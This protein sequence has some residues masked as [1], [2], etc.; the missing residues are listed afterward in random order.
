[1]LFFSEPSDQI[2]Y[3]AGSDRFIVKRAEQS[4][5]PRPFI[6]YSLFKKMMFDFHFCF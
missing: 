1:M 5:E 4:V 6:L 2:T 3:R